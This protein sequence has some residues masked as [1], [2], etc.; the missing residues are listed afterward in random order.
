MN[1]NMNT[2]ETTMLSAIEQR[3][4]PK[5]F[6]D[7]PVEAEKLRS[8]LDAARWAPSS[9]NEQPWRFIIATKENPVEYERLLGTLMEK[10]RE[11]AKQAPVLLVAIARQ[12]I[13]RT[14][15]PNT[16]AMY[17]VGGAIAHLTT[18]AVSLGL[19]VHQMGGFDADMLRRLYHIPDGFDP[20]TVNAIGYGDEETFQQ[21]VRTRKELNSLVYTGSWGTPAAIAG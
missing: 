16:H 15:S 1:M 9:R 14:G 6:L 3:R 4:S 10:N 11:W 13:E 8:I 21:H 5:Q 19:Q 17:D 18:Q 20:V 2:V 12:F 7:I